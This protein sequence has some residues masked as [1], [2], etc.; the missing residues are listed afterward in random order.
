MNMFTKGMVNVN[1]QAD[2]CVLAV[3]SSQRKGR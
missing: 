3:F 2:G 1:A